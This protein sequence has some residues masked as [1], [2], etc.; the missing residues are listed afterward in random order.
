MNQNSPSFNAIYMPKRLSP[1]QRKLTERVADILSYTPEYVD[2]A[3]KNIDVYFMRPENGGMLRV[4][5][6]DNESGMFYR[7]GDKVIE[8]TSRTLA[9]PFKKVDRIC[10]V[11]KDIVSGK[12]KTPDW[13]YDIKT[14]ADML[15]VNR[16]FDF[17]HR[18]LSDLSYP[19]I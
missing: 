7:A 13:E 17:T 16:N 9:Q 12:Y 10:K 6:L 2:A 19:R 11:L 1:Q 8:T 3:E 5:Y 18:R 15:R 14:D 4:A